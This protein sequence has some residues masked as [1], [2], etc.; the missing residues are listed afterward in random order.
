MEAA[1]AGRES[2]T[3]KWNRAKPAANII[4]SKKLRGTNQ[5][6]EACISAP[7]IFTLRQAFE[8]FFSFPIFFWVAPGLMQ[9]SKRQL[10]DHLVGTRPAESAA[11]RR[12]ALLWS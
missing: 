3:P 5:P 10:I 1:A 7:A 8:R 12:R 2:L 9:C 11:R 6:F 4:A